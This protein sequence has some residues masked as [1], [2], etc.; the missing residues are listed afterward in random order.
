MFPPF[1]SVFRTTTPISSFPQRKGGG[2]RTTLK[3]RKYKSKII[4]HKMS[5]KLEI[6]LKMKD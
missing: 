3:W 6:L 1:L 5:L 2:G 4:S